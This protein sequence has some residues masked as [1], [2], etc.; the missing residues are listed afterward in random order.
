M[1]TMQYRGYTAKVEY[2]EED[3]EFVGRVLGIRDV[4]GFHGTS[5]AALEKD[6]HA[7]LDFYLETCEKRG[8][9]PD[10]PYSGKLNVRL[11]PELHRA[12]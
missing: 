2:S 3:R 9:T 11:S 6:F 8:K 5:V 4:I 10:R 1:S 12:V 7:V